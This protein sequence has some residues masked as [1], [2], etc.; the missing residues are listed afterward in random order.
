MNKNNSL[1]ILDW[2][3]TLFPSTWVAKNYINLNNKEI[4]NRYL[5]F[6]SDLDDLI[7][8]LLKEIL[9]ISNII[10]VTNALPIWIKI[11][12][13]VL[14][15]TQYLLK[16]IKVISA[17]KNFQSISN[18]ATEWKKLAFQE[19]VNKLLSLKNKQNIISIGDASYEYN[20]LIN[21]YDKNKILKSVKFL[22]EPTHELLKEQI[23]VLT[24]NITNLI[25]Y[26]NH[27]DLLFNT[28]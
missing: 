17:R 9:E 19:E 8:V 10:I 14:P 25:S 1:V 28:L 2:D 4:R 11:S 7:F 21:L 24:A 3:N 12:S 18:D 23:E 26:D 27:L 22:D 15:K 5:N 6:F 13:S 20:A 16:N